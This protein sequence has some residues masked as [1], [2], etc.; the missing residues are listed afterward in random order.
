MRIMGFITLGLLVAI[1]LVRRGH[2]APSFISSRAVDTVP[3]GHEATPGI[4]R[5]GP[6]DQRLILQETGVFG[7]CYFSHHQQSCVVRCSWLHCYWEHVTVSSP[8]GLISSSSIGIHVYHR[9]CRQC[10]CGHR[11]KLLLL[12]ASHHKWHGCIRSP[13]R[14][15]ACCPARYGLVT[16]VAISTRR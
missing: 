1:N 15:V 10:K 5:P 11:Y 16:I 12:L 2:R 13:G 7:L 6:V 4:Q 9:Q 14:R 8:S 3:D